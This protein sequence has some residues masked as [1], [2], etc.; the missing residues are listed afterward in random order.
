[1]FSN[2]GG[3]NEN[4]FKKIEKT[5][6]YYDLSCAVSSKTVVF[7]GDPPYEEKELS[8]LEKGESFGLCRLMICNHA[9]THVDF[10]RHVL[11]NGKTSSDFPIESLIGKGR[12]IEVPIEE[13]SIT[14]DFVSLQQIEA[15]DFVFFKTANSLL[16]KQEAFT[17]DYVYIEPNAAEVL[18]KKEVKVVGIDYISVDAYS[19]ENLPVHHILLG[20]SILIVESLELREI[21]AGEYEI[22]IMPIKIEDKDGL[23]AR[24]LAKTRF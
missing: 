11:L 10:P 6:R 21:P 22:Q 2:S 16:S 9:G 20:Q 5:T 13:K 8:A 24:V 19:A 15:G 18:L 4:A 17:G 12:I 14:A 3:G 1:M 23:P 7:P